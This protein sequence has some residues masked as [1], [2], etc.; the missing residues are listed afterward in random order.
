[1]TAPTNGK[2]STGRHTAIA[3]EDTGTGKPLEGENA[4]VELALGLFVIAP[5]LPPPL[6]FSLWVFS[7]LLSSYRLLHIGRPVE[8]ARSISSI[9]DDTSSWREEP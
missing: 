3:Q 2:H 1:M 4:F 8:L 9:D 6:Y 5:L 7:L